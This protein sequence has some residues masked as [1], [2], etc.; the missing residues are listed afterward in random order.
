ME[1]LIPIVAE[2]A[3]SYT[4]CEHSSITYEKAQMLMEAV[5]YCMDEYRGTGD[6]ALLTSDISAKEAYKYGQEILSNKLKKLHNLYNELVI[7]FKD[8]GSKCL[9]STITKDIPAFLLKYDFKYATQKTLITLDYPVL[10]DLTALSGVN[11]VLEYI[12]C[13]YFEQLFLQKMDT[14]HVVEILQLYNSEYENLVE[15]ICE[16]VLQNTIGHI[17]IDKPLSS[18]EFSEK[19]LKNLEN[20]LEKESTDTMKIYVTKILKLLVENY[21]DDDSLLFNYLTFAVPNMVARIQCCL[22]N[23]CLGNIFLL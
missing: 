16:I 2:L 8:Y 19:E 5:V 20:L 14:N 18:K 10:K 1:E 13:I 4:G 6:N 12:E 7:S 23:K 15:N 9:K 17:I 11:C 21:Y 22:Q 3:Y